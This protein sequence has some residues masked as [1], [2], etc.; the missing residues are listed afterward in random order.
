M[1]RLA[2]QPV[3]RNY[4]SSARIK[5]SICVRVLE[6]HISFALKLFC[7]VVLLC[8][9]TPSREFFAGESFGI[10]GSSFQINREFLRL[11]LISLVM[12]KES[13]NTHLLLVQKVLRS[14]PSW[15]AYR[16][17]AKIEWYRLDFVGRELFRTNLQIN[18]RFQYAFYRL[19][20]VAFSVFHKI[21][22]FRVCAYIPS[23][24]FRIKFASHVLMCCFR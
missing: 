23:L 6:R 14:L 22:L 3:F 24:S 12:S 21:I 18:V 16:C 10:L 9:S 4:Y 2:A 13:M 11:V 7:C 15:L 5:F 17:R 20:R 19:L 1:F 8:G